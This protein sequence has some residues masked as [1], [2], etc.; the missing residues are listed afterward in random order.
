MF[1]KQNDR[2]T[3]IRAA[4][5]GPNLIIDWYF[6]PLG[7][8]SKKTVVLAFRKFMDIFEAVGRYDTEN[9]IK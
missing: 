2:R 6:P 4:M 1:A 5:S 8:F 7:A 9:I 3:I